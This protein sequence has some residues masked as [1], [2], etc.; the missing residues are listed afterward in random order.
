MA[1][2]RISPEMLVEGIEE[3]DAMVRDVEPLA[4]DALRECKLYVAADQMAWGRWSHGDQ[5]PRWIAR[6]DADKRCVR[7]ACRD[8]GMPRQAIRFAL[9][10]GRLFE[11]SGPA[12]FLAA[13]G[14]GAAFAWL[15][16]LVENP[17]ERVAQVLADQASRILDV[18][19]SE[20]GSR[21]FIP[22]DCHASS[23]D[24]PEEALA[25]REKW[26]LKQA[27]EPM[28]NAGRGLAMKSKAL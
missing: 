23:F 19:R 7:L 20:L 16:S 26:L 27:V 2:E 8:N 15:L 22:K 4:C 17:K 21:Q 1:A 13:K 28:A 9:I 10:R 24:R 5:G 3:L 11:S 18:L 25:I 6:V 14:D 12:E